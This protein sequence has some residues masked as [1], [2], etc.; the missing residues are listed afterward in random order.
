MRVVEVGQYFVT[1]DTGDFRQFQSVRLS[2]TPFHETTEL[3][4]QKDGFKET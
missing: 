2:R 1:K 4:N 3:L